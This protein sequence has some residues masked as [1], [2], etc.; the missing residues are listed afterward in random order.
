LDSG[1]SLLA[2]GVNS[3]GVRVLHATYEGLVWATRRESP[4]PFDREFELLASFREA[5]EEQDLDFEFVADHDLRAVL[6]NHY[7][8]ARI[9]QVAGAYNGASILYAAV[10]EGMLLDALM[11]PEVRDR[12]GFSSAVKSLR[13]PANRA[14]EPNWDKT[15]LGHLLNLAKA[16]GILSPTD[17]KLVDAAKDYRDAVHPK[18]AA[19]NH[20]VAGVEDAEVLVS[21]SRLIHARLAPRTDKE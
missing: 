17:G 14:G 8:E 18:N 15:S 21:L 13:V 1:R 3:E 4:L 9:I 6:T 12:E 2:S 19:R 5:Q 20:L 7:R 11:R 10:I 16:V